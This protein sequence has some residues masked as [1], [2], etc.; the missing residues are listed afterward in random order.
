[1]NAATPPQI[2]WQSRV[3][4]SL[5]FPT[6]V[7]RPNRII[8]S[9]NRRFYEKTGFVEADI[10]GKTCQDVM[11]ADVIEDGE[12]CSASS[13]P[14]DRTAA[15]G[16]GHSIIR[17]IRGSDGKTRWEDRVFS[18][19]LDEAGK[20][21]YII[22]SFRDV[23]KAKR[24]EQAF[25][26]I[27]QL[28]D[29][30][31]LSSASAIVAAD[32]SG[33]ILL[34]N[35]AA[36]KLFDCSF[37]Q[38]SHLT[39]RDLYPEGGAQEVMKRLRSDDYGGPGKL[40]VTKV[41]IESATGERI[42]VEMT[43]AIIYERD[44]ELATMG[45]YNDLRDRMALDQKLRETEAQVIQSEKMA[46]LGRLAAGVA[47]EI[48]NPLTG[49]VLYG[50]MALEKLAPQDPVRGHLD[51]ILEDAGRCKDIVQHLLAYS[52]QSSARREY[53]HL[54]Q[55]VEESLNLI[56]DQKL[57][58]NVVAR[59]EL[60]T[61]PLPVLADRNQM[62][63]VVINLVIN[64]IDAMDKRGTMT[65]R[66]YGRGED[67]KACL[68]VA[69]TGS[70]IPG[71]N[72]SRIF[73]PFFTTKAPGRGTGLGLSTAYGIVKDNGGTISVKSTGPGGTTFLIT[74]PIFSDMVTG[75]PESVG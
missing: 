38:G 50:N 52:R 15:S 72:L 66:T 67:K 44:E 5:S 31:V 35:P 55:L 54:N 13:C 12:L 53:F 34:M 25:Y 73:D 51:F 70:G 65:L 74:L 47:H 42:P 60:A 28:L 10:V 19:I 59:R 14:L 40:T 16:C 17:R 75:M 1:M 64:A 58:I 56:R 69:D 68:E 4:D 11:P 24:L 21:I 46:S 22:E 8:V 63:Q 39:T 33:R 57:F 3:F 43:G 27:R 45:I 18:P 32:R 29:R 37:S 23:T 20:V 30:V 36:E 7:L 26:G 49:I 6:L 9:A 48:N 2:D 41:D 71:E 62:R 61:M